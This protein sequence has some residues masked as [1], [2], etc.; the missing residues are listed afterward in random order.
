ML[1][2]ELR[3]FYV[4]NKKAF[5]KRDFVSHLC[6]LHV[7]SIPTTSQNLRVLGTGTWYDFASGSL[8]ETS[9]RVLSLSDRAFQ[10][11]TAQSIAGSDRGIVDRTRNRTQSDRT[12]LVLG[13]PNWI[14]PLNRGQRTCRRLN[15]EWKGESNAEEGKCVAA[16]G[17]GVSDHRD[18]AIDDE[19]S[20]T[21][22][23]TVRLRVLS[24]RV[25]CSAMARTLRL[26]MLV[27]MT[28]PL[29]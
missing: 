13:T 11:F 4:S 2:F 28:L 10:T 29:T 16:R 15:F 7:T 9:R 23:S 21:S 19:P 18:A 24:T 25:S 17:F 14:V 26:I 8:P 12:V 27:L 5:C 20:S 22:T 6:V 3:Y 1:D